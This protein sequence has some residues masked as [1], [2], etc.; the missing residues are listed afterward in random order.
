[1]PHTLCITKAKLHYTYVLLPLWEAFA[2]TPSP[3]LVVCVCVCGIVTLSI[4]DVHGYLGISR[5]FANMKL[6]EGNAPNILGVPLPATKIIIGGGQ[7]QRL[8]FHKSQI[9]LR[10]RL[11]PFLSTR[12]HLEPLSPSPS[13]VLCV[14]HRHIVYIY[15]VVGRPLV[16]GYTGSMS[17]R[18]SDCHG[19]AKKIT[20]CSSFTEIP[21]NHNPHHCHLS[22]P[23][24]GGIKRKL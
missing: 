16:T 2:T 15:V 10:L 24:C 11:T 23:F 8:V 6:W 3:S 18:Q 7:C 21:C 4:C 17:S 9:P 20:C 5:L 19:R 1:M 22:Y 12:R 14:W 13:V